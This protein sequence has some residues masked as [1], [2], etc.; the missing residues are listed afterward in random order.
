[1]ENNKL[2]LRWL[3]LIVG[4]I[5][6]LFVGIIYAWSILKAPLAAEFG[7]TPAQLSLNFTITMTFFCIGGFLGGIIRKKIGLKMALICSAFVASCGIGLSGIISSPNILALYVFYGLFGGLG[8]GISYVTIISSVNE[9][10]PDRKGLSSGILLMAFGASTLIMG[11][12]ADK[13]FQEPSIGW[14]NTYLILAGAIFIIVM[15][16]AFTV[17]EVGKDEE[18]PKAQEKTDVNQDIKTV[19]FKTTQIIKRPAFWL[20]FAMVV[21][22]S[23]TGNGTTSFAKDLM[24]SIGSSADAAVLMTGIFSVCNGISRV[25]F[26]AI[27]DKIGCRKG[28][29]LACIVTLVAGVVTLIAT[30]TSSIAIC[31]VGM[32]LAGFSFGSCPVSATNFLSVYYG[33]ENFGTNFALMNFNVLFTS[34]IATISNLIYQVSGAFTWTFVFILILAVIATILNFFIKQP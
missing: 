23:C 13:L 25:L 1:M 14:R 24:M 5:A 11:N 8:I 27:F 21:L 33:M 34:L 17:K 10:F 3:Y 28:M 22:L 30:I 31:C 6:L 15:I 20:A 26:G 16:A 4:T 7:W 9:R 29:N 2:K 32:C 18:L 12:I 19:Q